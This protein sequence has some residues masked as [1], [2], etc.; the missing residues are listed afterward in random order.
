MTAKPFCNSPCSTSRTNSHSPFDAALASSYEWGV[1]YTDSY[2]SDSCAASFKQDKL[3]K[4]S[5]LEM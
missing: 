2:C 5:R 3:D 1:R 4:R